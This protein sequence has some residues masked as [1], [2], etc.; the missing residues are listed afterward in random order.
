MNK[1]LDWLKNH[2]IFGVIIAVGIVII[3]L[4]NFTDALDKL[5]KFTSGLFNRDKIEILYNGKTVNGKTIMITEYGRFIFPLQNIAI[6]NTGNN[7]AKDLSIK[8]HFSR[9]LM[10]YSE[11]LPTGVSEIFHGWSVRN[12]LIENNVSL[13]EFDDKISL[14]PDESWS[15]PYKVVLHFD[16]RA[17]EIDSVS[18]KMTIYGGGEPIEVDLILQPKKS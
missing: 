12:S 16:K 7:L 13:M 4:G 17:T 10:K 14:H 5:S 9:R 6:R 18:S 3:A 1:Y 11:M 15:R 2:K 8:I